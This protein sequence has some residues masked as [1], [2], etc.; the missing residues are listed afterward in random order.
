MLHF[1][2]AE[3]EK[4]AG[5]K[6][7][8][9]EIV[10]SPLS[11][12]EERVRKENSRRTVSEFFARALLDW[13]SHVDAEIRRRTVDVHVLTFRRC[14][15]NRSSFSG[16]Q[17]SK[18]LFLE[19]TACPGCEVVLSASRVVLPF[20]ADPRISPHFF[21]LRFFI[22]RCRAATWARLDWDPCHIAC[23]LVPVTVTQAAVDKVDK[24][25][26]GVFHRRYSASQCSQRVPESNRVTP[27]DYS[28][29]QPT[30]GLNCPS[31]VGLRRDFVSHDDEPISV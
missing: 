11:S 28:I 27:C 7:T 25:V 8:R 26:A 6:R 4:T 9:L 21:L 20:W 15:A 3:R 22:A 16:E 23:Q 1:S 5:G 29:T 10:T 2:R 19:L 18:G 12:L 24:C 13:K 17:V 14:T 31:L 30:A